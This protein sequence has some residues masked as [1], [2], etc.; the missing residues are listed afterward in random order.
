MDEFELPDGVLCPLVT[1]YRDDGS[2][3]ETDLRSHVEFQVEA[4]ID[5][6]V[7]NGTTGEFASMDG[8]ERRRVTEATVEAVDGRVPVLAGAAA[9]TVAEAR[10]NVVTA[11]DA[12]ADGALIVVPY[13][14]AANDPVGNERFLR[15]VARD[16]PLP[17]VLYNI[18]ACTG[19][20]IRISTLRAM[21]DHRSVHGLK[22]SSGDF[23]YFMDAI[24]TTDDGFR[25]YQGFDSHLVPGMMMGADG[26]INALANAVPESFVAVREALSDGEFERAKRIQSTRI[27]PL[28]EYCVE[29]GFAPTAKAALAARDRLPADA[30]RPPLVGLPDDARDG[31]A[32]VVD[33]IERERSGEP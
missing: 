4:G 14:H 13:F 18:P 26:G 28:F 25:V 12:G 1:P 2:V 23:G 3:S 32:E 9:T 29:H 24:R 33:R 8:S 10:E 7:P 6:V 31:V 17:L 15:E 5:G 21:A 20:S 22:D 16:S 19:A 30:V 11:A 27:A